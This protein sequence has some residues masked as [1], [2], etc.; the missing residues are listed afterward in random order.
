ME[1][2]W[3]KARWS[4][5]LGALKTSTNTTG[6]STVIPAPL[7]LIVY[8]LYMPITFLDCSIFGL[9]M[10]LVRKKEVEKSAWICGFCHTTN[11]LDPDF[12]KKVLMSWLLALKEKEMMDETELP[13]IEKTQVVLCKH[14][15]RV[16]KEVNELQV[17]LEKWSLYIY[18]ILIYPVLFVLMAMIPG[19]IKI[20]KEFLETQVLRQ[21][22]RE[23]EEEDE[24]DELEIDPEI[25]KQRA[26][27]KELD[28][29]RSE[30]M[31]ESMKAVRDI[32]K[33]LGDVK[34]AEILA[35]LTEIHTV[36][37]DVQD[38]LQRKERRRKLKENR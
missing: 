9:V 29:K 25:A 38:R 28:H 22:K 23:E 37:Q 8:L 6:A 15:S 2:S 10:G 30:R 1:R 36:V 14:C 17:N 31:E 21:Q 11:K 34:S 18:Y 12:Q 26:R 27:E 13:I 5:T 3:T 32:F 7:N 16:K 19:I 35:K 20:I 24:E 33:E 4:S